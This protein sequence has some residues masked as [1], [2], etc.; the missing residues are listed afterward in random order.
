MPKLNTGN[1]AALHLAP[2]RHSGRDGVPENHSS[3]GEAFLVLLLKSLQ[4]LLICVVERGKCEKLWR[5]HGQGNCILVNHILKHWDLLD[6]VK[7]DLRKAI[8]LV[9]EYVQ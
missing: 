4:E 6:G 7:R 9:I 2:I 8:P 1:K 3:L 5:A